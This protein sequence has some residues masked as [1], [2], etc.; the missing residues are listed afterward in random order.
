MI[1]VV[2]MNEYPLVEDIMLVTV[3]LLTL[4]FDWRKF[5]IVNDLTISMFV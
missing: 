1:E 5:V 3:S 4:P 2:P